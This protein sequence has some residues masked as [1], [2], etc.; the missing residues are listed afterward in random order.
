VKSNDG[1]GPKLFYQNNTYRIESFF[2]GR[3]L[4]IWEMRNPMIGRKYA[5]LMVDY[6]FSP[7][8]REKI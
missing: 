6:N 8:A 3:P 5:E 1:T 7:V 4:S 2:E